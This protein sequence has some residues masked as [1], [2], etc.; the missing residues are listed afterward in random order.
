MVADAPVVTNAENAQIA[1]MTKVARTRMT[2]TPNPF[3][4]APPFKQL[5]IAIGSPKINV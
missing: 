2:P 3:L 1:A 5:T 4:A